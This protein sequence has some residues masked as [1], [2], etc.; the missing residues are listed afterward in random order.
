[1]ERRFTNPEILERAAKLQETLKPL[2][3]VLE[4]SPVRN[5]IQEYVFAYSVSQI[6]ERLGINNGP[7]LRVLL[8]FV[9]HQLMDLIGHTTL[10]IEKER[11][12]HGQ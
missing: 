7:A 12:T 8:D 2:V 3:E 4:Q 10:A 5:Q 9:D 11:E 1:M 6:A